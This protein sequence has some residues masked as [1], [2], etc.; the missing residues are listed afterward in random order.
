MA[1]HAV[2]GS[3]AVARLAHLCQRRLTKSVMPRKAECRV[4]AVVLSYDGRQLLEALL[5]SL[6]AQTRQ[7][8]EVI[9][10]DNGSSDGTSNWLAAEWPDVSVVRL[11][12]NIGVAAA[13]NCG[14]CAACGDYV[15]LLNNDVE[16]D[17]ECL[18]ELV[19]ALDARPDAGVAT[20]KLIDF[21]NRE[22]IDGA[23]DVYEWTGLASRRG[24]GERDVGQYDSPRPVFS[25][26]G[27]VA[28]YRRAALQTV[29]GFDEQLFA[30][31]EDVDWSFRAQLVGLSSR[32]VPTAIAY[33]MGS[34]TFGREPSD[35]TLYHYWRNTI[36]VVAKNYPASAL[37][38]HGYKFVNSQRGNLVW[39][40]KIGRGRLFARAWR[41][42]LR[43]M[44][45]IARKRRGIQRS[46]R[47]GL[48]ELETLIGA[49]R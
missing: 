11:P 12:G 31:Y 38:R 28:V 29:G 41:D 44:P 14:T 1:V 16:L 39:A 23:G 33:H 49:D 25:A 10:V 13:L 35:F 37:L 2:D 42:A 43:G 5:P 32:Y 3:V 15:A 47:I 18:S 17:P 8:D 19:R 4:S 21:H 6:A 7:A 22:V 27:C 48:T 30:Y 34:A 40:L 36:W 46:R 9:V 26:C 20:A 24:Q 45:A